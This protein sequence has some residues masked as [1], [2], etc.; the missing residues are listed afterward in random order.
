MERRL[1]GTAG[2]PDTSLLKSLDK[3]HAG[4]QSLTSGSELA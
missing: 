3:R 2:S 4:T 1:D